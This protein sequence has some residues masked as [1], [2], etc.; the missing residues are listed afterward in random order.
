MTLLCAYNYAAAQMWT[1][2]TNLPLII[3]DHVPFDNE[4]WN[5]FL[6]LLDIIQICTTRTVSRSLIGYL[7]ALIDIHHQQFVKCYPTASVIPKMHYMVH[8]PEQVLK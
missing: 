3:G 4:Q 8:F 2:V 6:V 7:E 1:L 5:C